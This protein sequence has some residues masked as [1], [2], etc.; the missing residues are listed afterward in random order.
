M[1]ALERSESDKI[2]TNACAKYTSSTIKMNEE[3]ATITV[4]RRKEL[5][6]VSQFKVRGLLL[7][8]CVLNITHKMA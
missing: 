8:I 2:C 7:N 3:K 4:P 6:Y 1:T 5:N